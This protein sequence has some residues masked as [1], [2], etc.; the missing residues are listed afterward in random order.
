MVLSVLQR[1]GRPHELLR[2]MAGN[3]PASTQKVRWPDAFI[4]KGLPRG[5]WRGGLWCV[6]LNGEQKKKRDQQRED[7]ERF[8]HG[9]AE[10]QAAELTV[11]CGRVAQG[12]RQI[13]A[14]NVAEAKGGTGHAEAGNA[15]TNVT[16]CFSFHVETPLE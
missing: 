6:G 12:A 13:A 10:N 9:E 8:G 4:P 2:M 15:C 3:H 14:K 1:L 7:A 11:S 5:V 16:S